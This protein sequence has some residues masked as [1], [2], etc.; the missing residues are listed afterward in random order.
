MR[1]LGAS[2]IVLRHGCGVAG[3]LRLRPRIFVA[4]TSAEGRVAARCGIAWIGTRS[5]GDQRFA[6]LARLTG[7]VLRGIHVI[8]PAAVPR[9]RSG[10]C[11]CGGSGG[12]HHRGGWLM[13]ARTRATPRMRGSGRD[14]EG[15]CRHEEAQ[16][17][18]HCRCPSACSGPLSR[19]VI[20]AARHSSG[21]QNARSTDQRSHYARDPRFAP[22]RMELT[23]Q[24]QERQR[25]RPASPARTCMIVAIAALRSPSPRTFALVWPSRAAANRARG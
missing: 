22:Q 15:S 12:R 16:G 19:A 1:L 8:E 4:C 25:R 11:G 7:H 5:A 17:A 20:R 21:A 23:S 10:R 3:V 9:R 13:H 24:R 14:R 2:L 18:F 6:I